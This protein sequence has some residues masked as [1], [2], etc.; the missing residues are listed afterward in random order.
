MLRIGTTDSTLIGYWNFDSGRSDLL[1]DKLSAHNDGTLTNV[2]VITND[3]AWLYWGEF[4]GASSEVTGMSPYDS[5]ASAFTV[6]ARYEIDSGDL[7]TNT[8]QIVYRPMGG[9]TG[10][11]SG[12]IYITNDEIVLYIKNTN[13]DT[14]TL[15]APATAGM[16]TIM[17]TFE[18]NGEARLYVDGDLAD[19]ISVADFD[20]EN[21]SG[22]NMAFGSNTAG[23]YA[24]GN[25]DEVR[26]YN[27]AKESYF[28]RALENA[29]GGMELPVQPWVIWESLN[30]Q[31]N[32]TSQVDRSR[33]NYRK[34]GDR[35]YLPAIDSEIEIWDDEE[36]VFGGTITKLNETVE[37]GADGLV[38]QVEPTDFTFEA[39]KLLI[40]R[41]YTDIKIR[42]IIA[43]MVN[44]FVNEDDLIED[45]DAIGS[46]VVGEDA[47]NLTLNTTSEIRGVSAFKFDIDVS[48][49]VNNYAELR[50]NSF[51]SINISEYI[52]S[53]TGVIH[54]WVNIPDVTNITSVS[55]LLAS[56]NFVN[57]A[58]F[59]S[60]LRIDGSPLANG[61]NHVRFNVEERVE[62]LTPDYTAI[63]HVILRI[64]YSAG[65]GDQSR[66]GFDE[67]R[68]SQDPFFVTTDVQGNFVV[69]KVVFNQVSLQTAMK[70]LVDLLDYNWYIDAFRGFQYFSKFTNV[71]PYNLT[72][73]SGNYFY[74]SLAR[75]ED[76]SQL[77]NR[78]KVRGGEFDGNTFTDEITV[79]GN[80]TKSFKLPYKFVNFTV[81]LNTV[82]QTVGIDNIDTFASFDVLYNFQE[83]NFRWESPRADADI[84]EFSGN[85]K[86][87]V[88]AIAEDTFSIAQF[89][90]IEKLIRDESI[91]DLTTARRRA[92][93]EL[94]AYSATIN[95]VKFIT[96]EQGLRTGQVINVNSTLRNLNEDFLI[97]KV[98]ITAQDPFTSRYNVELV[99][100]KRF[101][102]IALLQKILEPE[103]MTSDDSEVA[104][105]IQTDFQEV[106]ITEETNVVSAVEDFQTV[107]VTESTSKDPLGADT[108]PDWVL[109]KYVPSPWPTDPKREGR[110]DFSLEVY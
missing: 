50:N 84:I 104:E 32:L 64:N 15:T 88:L 105:K 93:A 55:V 41:A 85:P 38:Y 35:D 110:L 65:Q 77:A 74:K 68:I 62:T 94:L 61:W 80:D 59:T 18:R 45:C 81:K 47:I 16:H 3:E 21:N 56:D 102:F 4:N 92:A 24:N 53:G 69:D 2:T 87:P 33:F 11:R 103:A 14:Y 26:I 63:D 31:Q 60:S 106:I 13:G 108:E 96:D 34:Y 19:S 22:N 71:A 67:F 91:E 89:G 37:S 109:A 78:I 30:V 90:I 23:E 43:G 44:E 75:I 36:K 57:F 72:D 97:Q 9:N 28:A 46:W 86:T 73:S 79:S 20:S 66:F 12:S 10:N 7:D 48:A 98:V 39:S 42:D 70:K 95:D 29:G 6:F 40:T 83:K 99:S 107:T 1:K 82:L 8:H 76:G 101:D 52:T 58:T 49:S 17:G 5:L 27:E 100:T 25:L 51:G 54:G